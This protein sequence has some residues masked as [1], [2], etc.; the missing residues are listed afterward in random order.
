MLTIDYLKQLCF[1]QGQPDVD[2]LDRQD[3]VMECRAGMDGAIALIQTKNV[4]VAVVLEQPESGRLM[5]RNDGGFV[6]TVQSLWVM[7]Q[8]PFNG[9]AP[10]VMQRCMDRVVR[11]YSI[12]VSHHADRQLRRWAESNEVGYY[13]REANS[14]VGYEMTIHFREDKDLSY[15]R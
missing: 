13:A 3:W 6:D 4:P 7:E 14:Y 12:L 11:L 15:A 5:L 10:E 8:V 1:P 9:N 2:G